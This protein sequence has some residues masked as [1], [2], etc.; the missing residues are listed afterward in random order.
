MKMFERLRKITGG[1]LLVSLLM[2][3]FYKPFQQYIQIPG[4]ITL[5]EGQEQSI[6]KG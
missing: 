2:L 6:S 1:I 5:F 3:V 4:T